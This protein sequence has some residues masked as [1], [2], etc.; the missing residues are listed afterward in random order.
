VEPFIEAHFFLDEDMTE[1]RPMPL[2][3]G[4]VGVC[5]RRCPGSEAPNEDAVA[6]IP[7][8]E[9][10]AVLAL[11]DGMG[12]GQAGERAAGLALRELGQAIQHDMALGKQLRTAILNGIER[13]NQAVLDLGLGAGSTL[14]VAEVDDGTIR[15]Y[16]VGDSMILVVGQRGRVKLQ[17]VSHSPVGY[18]VESG[19]MDEKAALHHE[20]R[21]VISNYVGST[22]MRVEVGS[23]VQLARRDTLLLASDGLLDNLTTEEIIERIRKGPLHSV[24]AGLARDAQ[25]RMRHPREGLP[26]KPD[27]LTYVLYRPHPPVRR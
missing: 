19:Y 10:A 16:H 11:A 17:T 9:S 6:V 27:D 14:A 1:P 20:D 8:G 24:V 25:E 3:G 4:L 15:P 22:S 21:H 5:S 18:A 13:A 2:A 26:S 23:S 12:G 7:L